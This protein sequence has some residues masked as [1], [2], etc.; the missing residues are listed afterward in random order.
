MIKRI[1]LMSS[2]V[3]ALTSFSA[4]AGE[5]EEDASVKRQQ[6][7]WSR[8]CKTCHTSG[9]ALAL[10]VKSKTL[11]DLIRFIKTG[12]GKHRFEKA[13]TTGEI[14]SLAEFIMINRLLV[15]LEKKQRVDKK[16]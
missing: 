15:N 9:R 13:L 3:I 12:D 8:D 5:K 16:K 2:L 14:E 4:M 10:K 11:L 6:M 7:V 1:A